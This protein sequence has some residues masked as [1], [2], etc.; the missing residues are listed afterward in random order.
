MTYDD[1]HMKHFISIA[2]N[3]SRNFE[4]LTYKISEL[5]H[6]TN[7]QNDDVNNS[8]NGH[9]N[10]EDGEDDDYAGND[11]SDYNHDDNN[12]YNG[13]D[14]NGDSDDSCYCRC[15]TCL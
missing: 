7:D 13:Y 6:G 2:I 4:L 12:E 5:Q 8:R 11:A 15:F 3:F 1:V 9:H 14:E 10:N